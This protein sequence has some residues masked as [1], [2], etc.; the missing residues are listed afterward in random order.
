MVFLVSALAGV[1]FWNFIAG[2]FEGDKPKRSWRMSL[3]AY[4]LHV[5]HWLY[6]LGLMAA[7]YCVGVRAMYAYGFLTGSVAQGLTYRDWYLLVYKKSREQAIYARWSRLEP[8]PKKYE[9]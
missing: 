3:G 5:H 9:L 1:L 8:S 2:R 6:C 7:F 4:Y